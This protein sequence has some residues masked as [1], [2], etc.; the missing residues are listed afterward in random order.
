MVKLLF[1]A[2]VAMGI[3]L[4]SHDLCFAQDLRLYASACRSDTLA[5]WDD[6]HCAGVCQPQTEFDVYY[7]LESCT[8]RYVPSNTIQ[9]HMLPGCN[10]QTVLGKSDALY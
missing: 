1:G 2:D 6:T 4:L 10:N 9:L 3:W 5:V 8:A 7:T